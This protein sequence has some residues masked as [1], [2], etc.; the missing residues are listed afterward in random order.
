MVKMPGDRGVKALG[1]FAMLAGPALFV[2]WL[3]EGFEE[4]TTR[5][6]T[7]GAQLLFLLGW[8]ASLLG[9]RRIRAAGPGR[10]Q[11]LLA[12]QLILLALAATQELQDL[13]LAPER[14]IQPMYNAADAAWPLSVIFM[15]PVGI[16]VARAG[17][18]RGWHRFA[19]GFCA[20]TLPAALLISFLFGQHLL[21]PVFGVLTAVAWVTLGYAVLRQ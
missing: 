4:P 17:V 18:L 8:S 13:F 5:P 10:G 15:L 1:A 12:I 20:V 2:A 16:A 3:A 7:V 19:P 14:R 11:V 9:L 6:F 21:V